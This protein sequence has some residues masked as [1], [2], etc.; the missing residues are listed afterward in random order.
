MSDR[1][2]TFTRDYEFLSNFYPSEITYDGI[3]YPTVEHAYQAAKSTDI[4]IRQKIAGAP[5]PGEAKKLGRSVVLRKDWE[6]IKEYVMQRLLAAKFNRETHPEL[7]WKL[8]KTGQAE[9]IEGN[10]WHD[11]YWGKCRCAIHKG[12]GNNRLGELLMELR[13]KIRDE[14]AYQL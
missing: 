13:A 7:V 14:D 4:S 11:R 12:V 9:L 8:L 3:L 10:W 5:T 2:E 6:H 1:I